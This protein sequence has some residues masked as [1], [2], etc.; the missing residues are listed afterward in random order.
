M[1]ADKRY[2]HPAVAEYFDDQPRT[3]MSARTSHQR[4]PSV[5]DADKISLL[6]SVSERKSAR[7][8]E[9][10]HAN[11]SRISRNASQ[12]SHSAENQRYGA[13]LQI[14]NDLAKHIRLNKVDR[15]TESAFNTSW[16]I[17]EASAQFKQKVALKHYVLKHQKVNRNLREQ[18][19]YREY[20]NGKKRDSSQKHRE[21]AKRQMLE[22]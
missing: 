6:L 20:L 2:S 5:D 8:L 1:I 3:T 21:N 13:L 11:L 19:E 4:E 22:R 7:A 12:L 17:R 14:K 15:S 10:K 16:Q 9:N 18:K